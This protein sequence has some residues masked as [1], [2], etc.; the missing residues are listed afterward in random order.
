MGLGP[1]LLAMAAEGRL[2]IGSFQR[3]RRERR[4]RSARYLA[5]LH[6]RRTERSGAVKTGDL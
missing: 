2:T 4:T 3:L 6:E 1:T 5:Q